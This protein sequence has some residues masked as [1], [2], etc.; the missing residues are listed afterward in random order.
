MPG[1]RTVKTP[2]ERDHLVDGDVT[3]LGLVPPLV[4]YGALIEAAIAQ[5]QAVGD[6]DE[7]EIGEHDPGTLATVIDQDLDAGRLE[8]GGDV[9][10][11]RLQA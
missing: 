2:H 8:L 4:L 9:L 1:E 7:I 10:D 11:R 3:G 5:D 6:A